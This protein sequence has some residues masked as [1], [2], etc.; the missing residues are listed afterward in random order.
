MS[1]TEKF[2]SEEYEMLK[3]QYLEKNMEDSESEPSLDEDEDEDFELESNQ[4]FDN[5]NL[6]EP[7]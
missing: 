1:F 3:K 7:P 6:E 2:E 4:K 5:H